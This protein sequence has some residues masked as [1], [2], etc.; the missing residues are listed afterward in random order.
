YTVFFGGE[1]GVFESWDVVNR[2]ITGHGLAVYASFGSV[3]AAQAA[4]EYARSK[5]WTSDSSTAGATNLA[6]TPSSNDYDDND[7]PL[8]SGGSGPWYAVARGAVPGVYRS[9]L[10]CSLNTSGIRGN[11]SAS[12]ATREQAVKAYNEALTAGFV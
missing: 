10:E 3:A 11:L 6:P 5:G 8:N 12:F 7:N 1:V 2:S 9:Y 4:L